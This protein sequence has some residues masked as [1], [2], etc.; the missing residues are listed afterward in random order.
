[1]RVEV[2]CF[3]PGSA[4]WSASFVESGFAGGRG[5]RR[6]APIARVYVLKRE[7]VSGNCVLVQRQ[8]AFE[9]FGRDRRSRLTVSD[10]TTS[11][12]FLCDES[13]WRAGQ[14]A[15]EQFLKSAVRRG[16]LRSNPFEELGGAA[17]GNKA[18][19]YFVTREEIAK[20]MAACPDREWRLIVA[21][22]DSAGS[23]TGVSQPAIVGCRLGR[24]QVPRAFAE[25]RASPQ[26]RLPMGADL[27]GTT[28]A[29]SGCLRSIGAR[30][31]A[32][33]ATLPQPSEPR[34]ALQEDHQASRPEA[35]AEV[36]SK[37]SKYP[38]TEL[39]AKSV[40]SCVRGSAKGRRCPGALPPN[41]GCRL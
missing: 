31:S 24:Q 13:R 40:T 26:R 16:L 30:A 41:D 18:R 6:A 15:A 7:K 9:F 32:L 11:R 12:P 35:L 17:R 27:S 5:R 23:H 22:L 25:D 3:S 29:P 10:G 1:M 33:T 34:H 36:V 4:P 14:R 37:P 28:A 20:V 39:A 21:L 19:M 38:E 8:W 2:P